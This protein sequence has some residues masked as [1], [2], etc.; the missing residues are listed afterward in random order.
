MLL[1]DKRI[2]KSV[3]SIVER[4]PISDHLKFRILEEENILG[5]LGKVG[6]YKELYEYRVMLELDE[7]WWS[8]FTT[9]SNLE[10]L[11][12][13]LSQATFNSSI[14]L[15]YLTTLTSIISKLLN[16]NNTHSDHF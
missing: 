15:E 13:K 10:I 1:D 11:V 5:A 7:E 6:F 14:E 3:W 12:G 9:K 2:E 4:L 8:I 16:I